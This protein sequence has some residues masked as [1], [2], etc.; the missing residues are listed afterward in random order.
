M[1]DQSS[2][3][4]TFSNNAL[5]AYKMNVS[6]GGKQSLLQDTVWDSKPQKMGIKWFTK[7]LKQVLEECG[8]DKVL[9]R[10]EDFQ[11]S[12]DLSRRVNF[13]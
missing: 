11:V 1:F 7:V 8:N 9:G 10:N 2:G 3:Y 6:A 5:I 12:K 13:K 4:C